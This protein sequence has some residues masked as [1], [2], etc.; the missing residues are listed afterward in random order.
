MVITQENTAVDAVITW[1]VYENEISRICF[2]IIQPSVPPK[3]RDEADK[4]IMKKCW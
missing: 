2:K 4:T 3:G 1:D